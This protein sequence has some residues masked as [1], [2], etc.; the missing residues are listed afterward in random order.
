MIRTLAADLFLMIS[1]GLVRCDRPQYGP[2]CSAHNEVGTFRSADEEG[3]NI[4]VVRREMHQ[5]RP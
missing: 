5:L 4:E 1:P 3:H 2:F